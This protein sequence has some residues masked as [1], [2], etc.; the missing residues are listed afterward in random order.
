MG[1]SG[2][3][4]KN[5][6]GEIAYQSFRPASLPPALNMDDEMIRTLV[7]ANKALAALDTLSLNI[8]NMNLFVSMYVRKEALL[9][10]QIE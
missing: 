8:P 2:E 10:S 9:S 7:Q 1:R 3:Y 4:I 6:S 5:L